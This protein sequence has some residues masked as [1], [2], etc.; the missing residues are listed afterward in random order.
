MR[1]KQ[2]YALNAVPY[3]DVYAAREKAA[4]GDLDGAVQQLRTI[5]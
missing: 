5:T 4:L 3:F 1:P 2:H